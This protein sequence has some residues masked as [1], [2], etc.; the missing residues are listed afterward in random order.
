MGILSPNV[1]QR[2]YR[3]VTGLGLELL[4]EATRRDSSHSHLPIFICHGKVANGT[5]R[6]A[7]PT[8]DHREAEVPELRSIRSATP[9]QR[10]FQVVVFGML[11]RLR[12]RT[13]HHPGTSSTSRRH[14]TAGRG[15]VPKNTESITWSRC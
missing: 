9:L 10:A 7:T 14:T 11:E 2:C 6:T 15:C 13:A 4:P 1:W 12:P 3:V 5:I 8:H